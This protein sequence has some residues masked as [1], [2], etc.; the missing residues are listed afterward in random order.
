MPIQFNIDPYP[1]ENG[2]IAWLSNGNK[3]YVR[4]RDQEAYA[5]VRRNLHN[6]RQSEGFIN[7][8]RIRE[9]RCVQRGSFPADP[10]IGEGPNIEFH[11]EVRD[12]HRD[13][14]TTYQLDD[15]RTF[16]LVL[17]NG[18][19]VRLQA[20]DNNTRDEWMR[21][22]DALVRYWKARTAADTAELKALRHRNIELL[23]IDEEMESLLGQFAQKWEVRRAQTSPLLYNL[24]ALTGCRAIKVYIAAHVFPCL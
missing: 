22:L 18:L 24:C 9:V 6:L 11:Q 12:T 3:H 16:E 15:N 8:C 23:G 5:H 10:N 21:R 14:G 20:Y 2:D 1:I 19:V 17:N 7:L 4:N 13:D